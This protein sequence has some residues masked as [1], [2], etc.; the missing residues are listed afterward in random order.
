MSRSTRLVTLVVS[1]MSATSSH[2]DQLTAVWNGGAGS[3]NTAANWS[4]G[5]VPNNG[6]DTHVALIDSGK[7]PSTVTL[8][9]TATIDG[10][11]LDAD[12]VVNVNQ[13]IVLV[14]RNVVGLANNGQ[15]NI[16]NAG[17]NINAGLFFSGSQTITGS[18]EIV[19]AGP[20]IRAS[21]VLT[22]GSDHTIRGGGGLL[23]DTGGMINNGTILAEGSGVLTIDP[24]A[25]GFTNNA[26]MQATGTGGFSF[27][28]G[29]FNN[30]STIEVFAGSR[31]L[32]LLGGATIVG[33]TL[34]TT[35]SG[36]ILNQSNNTLDGVTL[37]GTLD[38]QGATLTILNGLTNNGQLNVRTASTI[39]FFDGAQTVGGTGQ[40]VLGTNS[41]NTSITTNSNFVTNGAAHEIRGR[42]RLL[43]DTG[44]MINDGTILADLAQ[45]LTI[46]P[47]ELGFTNNGTVRATGTGGL[48]MTGGQFTNNPGGR[49][50]A[51]ST[52]TLDASATLTNDPGGILAGT[53]TFVI[54]GALNQ[55]GTI[56]PGN[57]TGTLTF[58]SS[59]T[60]HGSS[61]LDIEIAG[62]GDAD[63]L[64]VNGTAT[65]A[66]TLNVTLID[67]GGGPFV[68]NVGDMFTILTATSPIT[69]MFDEPV[70]PSSAGGFDV[71]WLVHYN[72]LD[73]TLEVASVTAAGLPGDYNQNGVVDAADY[74]V[75]RDT[76]GQMG[77]DLAAD[78]S[79]ATPGV[80]D[81]TVD[82]LDYDLWKSHFGETLDDGAA[83]IGSATAPA[84]APEPANISLIG[85]TVL[86]VSLLR[87]QG[88]AKTR[89][90]PA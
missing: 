57:S 21:G 58:S 89:C 23:Q 35:G 66:G 64:V 20:R 12:D 76:L 29:T 19:M 36:Q 65:L 50:T 90:V 28:D 46:D 16:I 15:I 77:G 38:H 79:G 42:G 86:L 62:V 59:I 70:L 49:I 30:N 18:G 71:D 4:T 68:P 14:V 74:T 84:A 47:N 55:L 54:N 73:V 41:T 72:V 78:G 40:I 75:W 80:P 53:G 9:F 48:T 17:P 60:N 56:A 81:G 34:Q 25:A 13:D 26:T 88:Y 7:P 33:G 10:M 67:S 2:A 6:T 1:L 8:S 63:L 87:R 52:M 5:V 82:Q 39:L 22:N 83:A 45:V 24:S 31:L 32:L 37:D 44:G 11:T 43:D 3:W 85:V 27:V 51:D 61:V 69:T